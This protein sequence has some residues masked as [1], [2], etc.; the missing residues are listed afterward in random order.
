[1]NSEKQWKIME[2]RRG[3]EMMKSYGED[4]RKVRKREKKEYKKEVLYE[5]R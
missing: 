5:V 3:K 1:M 2:K 4:I